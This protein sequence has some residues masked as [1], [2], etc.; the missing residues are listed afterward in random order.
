M[1]GAGVVVCG[2]CPLAVCATRLEAPSGSGAQLRSKTRYAQL[3]RHLPQGEFCGVPQATPGA[4]GSQRGYRLRVTAA[5]MKHRAGVPAPPL[6]GCQPLLPLGG[7][8]PKP[9]GA[10]VPRESADVGCQKDAMAARSKTG[11]RPGT[12]SRCRT[13]WYT[14]VPRLGCTRSRAKT[15]HQGGRHDPCN[16]ATAGCPVPATQDLAPALA[17][18]LASGRHAYGRS[19]SKVS[20]VRQTQHPE[21]SLYVARHTAQ[22]TLA[23]VSG[24][25]TIKNP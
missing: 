8:A 13:R 1:P 7:S 14:M 10:A 12:P 5:L 11:A 9:P 22:C 24:E 6:P 3:C 4:R 23:G 25:S 18:V 20:A 17:N 16:K 21:H 19:D 2:R 15:G